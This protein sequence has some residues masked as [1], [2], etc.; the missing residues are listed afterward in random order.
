MNLEGGDGIPVYITD[1][2]DLRELSVTLN[3]EPGAL[4][5]AS[6]NTITLASELTDAGWRISSTDLEQQNGR[7]TVTL[8]GTSELEALE[9]DRELFRIDAS[10]PM[11][12]E[13]RSEDC[14]PIRPQGHWSTA[15][16]HGFI[17]SDENR[18]QGRQRRRR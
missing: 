8:T 9:A 5:L 18:Y 6:S 15:E 4:T 13:F 1:T 10:V 17:R 2:A 7:L 12:G 16:C 3:F 11:N 14:S